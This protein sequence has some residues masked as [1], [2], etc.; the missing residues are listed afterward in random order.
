MDD[1]ENNTRYLAVAKIM[2]E[3]KET[4]AKVLSKF[5]INELVEEM[6]KRDGVKRIPITA[7]NVYANVE[8]F[9]MGSDWLRRTPVVSPATILV[10]K[11]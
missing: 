9:G 10:I 1:D 8:E 7:A 3:E 11:E 4:K 2:R 5:P 6:C